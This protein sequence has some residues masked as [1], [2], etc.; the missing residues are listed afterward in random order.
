MDGYNDLHGVTFRDPQEAFNSALAR[1]QFNRTAASPKYVGRFMY[2]GTWDGKDQ[3]KD[4]NT[5]RY[6]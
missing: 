5:R 6:L 1:S 3:F 4:I 2:M